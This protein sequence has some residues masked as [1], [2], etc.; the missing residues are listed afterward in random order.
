MKNWNRKEK[1]MNESNKNPSFIVDL[2]LKLEIPMNFVSLDTYLWS[3][4]LNRIKIAP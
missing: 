3:F 1:I 2:L 4:Q